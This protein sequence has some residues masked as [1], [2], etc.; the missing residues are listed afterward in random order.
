MNR[1]SF[2]TSRA[3]YRRIRTCYRRIRIGCIMSRI[4]CMRCRIGKKRSMIS[5]R[6]GRTG[7]RL[8]EEQVRL[9]GQ[10]HLQDEHVAGLA[11]D[12]A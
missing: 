9:G 2:W 3:C 5:F 7:C 11:V 1:I 10:D 8:K 12:D 6:T 4:G